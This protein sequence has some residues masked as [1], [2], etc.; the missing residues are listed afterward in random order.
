MI[1]DAEVLDFA[2]ALE[3]VKRARHF[4]R[5]GQRIRPVQQQDVEVIGLQPLERTVDGIGDVLVT[6]IVTAGIA[7]LWRIRSANAAFG[8]EDD[9]VAQARRLLQHPAKNGFGFSAGINVRVI[10]KVDALRTGAGHQI[11]GGFIFDMAEVHATI[12]DARDVKIGRRKR[13]RFH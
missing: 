3:I 2:G 12:G 4:R 6:E 10:K 9:P 5:F 7:R 11:G 8:L 13:I 1:A